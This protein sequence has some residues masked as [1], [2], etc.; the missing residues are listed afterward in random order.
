MNQVLNTRAVD[1]PAAAQAVSKLPS[2]FRTLRGEAEYMAAY[3]RSM[4]LWTVPY[5]PVDIPSRFGSTHVVICGSRQAPPLVLLHCFATSLT[6]WAYNV[7]PLSENRRVYALDMMGQ[8]SK[9]IPN[10]PIKNRDELA[11]W[12]TDTL[13][14]LGIGRTDL[15]GYSF[16]AFTGLNYAMRAPDRLNKL[17]LLSP[18]GSLVP[19]WKQFYIRGIVST[20]LPSLSGVLAKRLWFDWMFHKPNLDNA[21]T[22]SLYDRLLTQFAFGQRHFRSAGG[23]LPVAYEDQE[24]RTVRAPTLVLIGQQ[25]SL[26]DPIAAV[27]RAK[28]LIPHVQAELIPRASHDLPISQAE[29]VNKRVLA[30]LEPD[31]AGTTGGVQRPRAAEHT[32]AG[33]FPGTVAATGPARTATGF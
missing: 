14:Q 1:A 2:P 7:P 21:T 17:V 13:D 31:E 12:L 16:G 19:L 10:Q 8:P 4:Q 3:E 30:F 22:R 32:H 25:E 26:L 11:E 23:V 18:A 33:A 6:C 28:Q 5:E 15:I 9:S 27:R 24:L 20:L 29:I